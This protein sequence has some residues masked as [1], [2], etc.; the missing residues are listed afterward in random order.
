MAQAAATPDE[1]KALC[2]FDSEPELIVAD[3]TTL[4]NWATCPY[5]AKQIETGVIKGVGMLAEAGEEIHRAFGSTIQWYID[6][7]G[8]PDEYQGRIKGAITEFLEAEL[9][10]SR[11][12]VQPMVLAGARASLWSFAEFLSGIM[13]GNIL[14]FDGGLD[15]K[16]SQ[17]AK[18]L[19]GLGVRITSEL[20]LVVATESFEVIR[21]YDWKSGWKY[22]TAADVANAFQFQ[23]HAVLLFDRHPTI[24]AVEYVVWDTRSNK[25]TYKVVFERKR[26]DDY[27]MRI[28]TAAGYRVQFFANPP[29]WPAEEKCRICRAAPLCPEADDL[30]KNNV[31]DPS[32]LLDQ[33]I[34]SEAR[35]KSLKKSLT[36]IHDETKKPIISGNTGFA[37]VKKTD[38]APA[39]QTYRL[40]ATEAESESEET[41]A[42]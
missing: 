39:A 1:L 12:D 42:E 13:P 9:R 18:D 7:D 21:V 6:C 20:D 33:Y 28:R 30:T 38:R 17:L 10:G 25:R 35:C 4:E 24:Q 37:R 40:K 31:S 14:Y 22:H 11:P 26:Y 3:R 19:G 32:A 8:M 5:Q 41:P 23:M 16:S 29:A 27:L 34:A 15:D 2:P 36:A